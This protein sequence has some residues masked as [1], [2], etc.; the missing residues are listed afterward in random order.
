MPSIRATIANAVP[1]MS[2]ATT[3]YRLTDF[4]APRFWPT[5]LGLGLLRLAVFLPFAWQRVLG[6]AL[7]ALAYRLV[8]RRR[9]IVAT[10]IRLCFPELSAAQQA[11]LVR[12]NFASTGIS[13]FETA[14][15]WWASDRRLAPLAHI[16]GLEHLQGALA[17]GRGVLLLSA[18]MTGLELGG[19]L[20]ALHQPFQVIYKRAHNPLFECFMHR[21]R[22]R[23][24]LDAIDTYDTRRMVGAL[25]E[26]RATWYAMDQ[27]FG[28]KQYVFAPFMGVTACTLTTT[29]RLVRLSGALVVPYFP[30]RRAD[31]SYRIVIQP[32]LDDFPSGDELADAT[33]I[34]A[35][36]E[37]AVRESPAQYFWAHRRFKTRPPGEPDLYARG[38]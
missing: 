1:T 21:A 2:R 36:I 5:W 23:H 37:A 8:P 33:R 17:T 13:I 14:M 19:R 22:Q 26:N 24:F 16:E 31:G 7:G 3:D 30:H 12:E 15:S 25:K 32:P 28:L 10:N 27:D 38:P 29:S 6:R 35:L 20:L 34:N 18:H 9:H 4:L 11:A